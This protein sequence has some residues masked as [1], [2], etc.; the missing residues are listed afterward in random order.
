MVHGHGTR[1]TGHDIYLIEYFRSTVRFLSKRMTETKCLFLC[2]RRLKIDR[3][4]NKDQCVDSVTGQNLSTRLKVRC[5]RGFVNKLC[6]KMTKPLKPL[7][8][9][10]NGRSL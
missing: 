7:K 1:E 9:I 10:V 8:R 5:E 3:T 6:V 4:R 2:L